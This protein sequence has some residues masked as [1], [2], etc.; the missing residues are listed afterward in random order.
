MSRLIHKL[1]ILGLFLCAFTPVLA[2]TAAEYQS[3]IQELEAKISSLKNQADTLANQVAYY[4]SQISLTAIKISQTEELINTLSA[5]IIDLEGVLDQS[6]QI[7]VDQIIYTYKTRKLDPFQLFLANPSFTKY[8]NQRKY[9]SLI[10]EHNRNFIHDAQL[11]QTTYEDQ[12]TLLVESQKK[13]NIQK[14]S[15]AG[16]RLER[17]NLLKQT[18]NNEAT[19]QKQLEQ[20][21]LELQ[22]INSALASASRVGP[23]KA[24]DQAVGV[25]QVDQRVAL[26]VH[27]AHDAQVLEQKRDALIEHLL[28]L[29][30]R[31]RDA[32]GPDLPAGDG[33]LG[34]VLG[35]P[36]SPFDA[37]GLGAG[38]I[39]RHP[40]D[41]RVVVSFDRDLVIGSDQLERGVH[42]ADPLGPNNAKGQHGQC[43]QQLHGDESNERDASAATSA[44]QHR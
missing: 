36:E 13:L 2:K 23:V 10:Q 26:G 43:S 37:P 39:T 19:Y 21:K 24:V 42:R 22:A 35:Q 38:D 4:D 9:I 31:G 17:D 30:Q 11:A 44:G 16:L 34:L 29:R 7:L 27:H 25:G 32:D 20:A 33:G 41:A 6:T 12:K 15:L 3:E 28:L 5:K 1:V 14:A 8:F 40:V 18:K